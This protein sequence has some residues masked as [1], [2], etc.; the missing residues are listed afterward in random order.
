MFFHKEP[1]VIF[2]YNFVEVLK[3]SIVKL[4]DVKVVDATQ[5]M[6]ML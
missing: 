4:A 1:Q 3:Q 6:E 2:N 5:P